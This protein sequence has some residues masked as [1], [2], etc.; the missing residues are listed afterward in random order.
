MLKKKIP[1]FCSEVIEACNIIGV[2][3]DEL[4]SE[5]D[6]RQ[7]LKKKITEIQSGELLKRMTLSS[8]MDRVIIGGY[9]YKGNMMNYL[10]K[11]NFW[12]ARAIFMARYQMW[13]TKDNFPG[14]WKGT[15][16]NCCGSRD[17]DEHILLCPG[18]ADIVGGKFEFEVFWDEEVLKNVEKLKTIADTVLLLIERMEHIQSLDL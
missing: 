13:P 6:V 1:G 4:L 5:N 11:L 17:T 3:I 18:Y 7:V 10:S 15:N 14:R 9:G 16:C 8:K 12:Q 2:S